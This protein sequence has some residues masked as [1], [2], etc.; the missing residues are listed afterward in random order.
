MNNAFLG[1]IGRYERG[2]EQT[3]STLGPIPRFSW[4]RAQTLWG[5]DAID[6]NLAAN[7]RPRDERQVPFL[8]LRVR[9][10]SVWHTSYS[11]QYRSLFSWFLCTYSY[12]PMVRFSATLVSFCEWPSVKRCYLNNINTGNN[13]HPCLCEER[14]HFSSY[15]EHFGLSRLEAIAIRLDIK[16]N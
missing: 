7:L 6:G 2:S 3:A 1:A 4:H 16:L 12:I 5:N 14:E 13:S 15:L 9:S 8:W 10:A 11:C